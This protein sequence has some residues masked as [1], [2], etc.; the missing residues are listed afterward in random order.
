MDSRGYYITPFRILNREHFIKHINAVGFEENAEM[1][2]PQY[3]LKYITE[4]GKNGKKIFCFAVAV[5]RR[6][7]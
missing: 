3:L 4:S 1:F 5:I 6:L 2:N 7:L